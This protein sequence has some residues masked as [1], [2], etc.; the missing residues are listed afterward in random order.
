MPRNA[1]IHAMGDFHLGSSACR[2]ELLAEQFVKI[3]RTS[4]ARVILMGDQFDMILVD[5]KRRD[6]YSCSETLRIF[7]DAYDWLF[8]RLRPI[9][10]KI[11]GIHLGNHE[12]RLRKKG[13]DAIRR[14]CDDLRVR[15]FGAETTLELKCGKALSHI[16]SMHGATGATMPATRVRAAYLKLENTSEIVDTMNDY[17]SIQG[18]LYGHTHDCQAQ[19]MPRKTVPDFSGKCIRHRQQFVCLTGSYLESGQLWKMDYGVEKGYNPLAP[20]HVI[21]QFDGD[22]IGNVRALVHDCPL[23]Y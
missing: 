2:E 15:Y 11:I 1:E 7:D 21:I 10:S 9:K 16:R 18:I 14:L 22:H 8:Q 12:N 19:F 20:G 3:M 4:Q 13:I 5:D 17:R 23:A 6:E